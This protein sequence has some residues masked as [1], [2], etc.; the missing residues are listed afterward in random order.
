MFDTISLKRL[1]N[2][3]EVERFFR[4]PNPD[5]IKSDVPSPVNI[6]KTTGF[7]GLMF[8]PL[9]KLVKPVSS[10]KTLRHLK[11]FALVDELIAHRL[12]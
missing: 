4:R 8:L 11:P 5:I 2:T 6:N 3:E 7:C 9:H 10:F 12:I 1:D